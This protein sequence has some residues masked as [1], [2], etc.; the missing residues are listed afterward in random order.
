MQHVRGIGLALAVLASWGQAG[1]ATP[2]V[3]A[4]ELYNLGKFDDAIVAARRALEADADLDAARVV[5]ARASLERYRLRLETADRTAAEAA[6]RAVD[7]NRLAPS[8]Y[9]E[10]LVGLG[11]ALFVDDEGGLEDRFSAAAELFE[12]VL[13]RADGAVGA[14]SR[15]RVLEW[16]ANALDRQAQ[17]GPASGRHAT[18]ARLLERIDREVDANDRSV[19]ALY[20]Q[21]VASRGTGDLERAWGAAVAAW[22]RSR[23]LGADGASLRADLDRFVTTVLLPERAM[24][25]APDADPRPTLERLESGWR[26]FKEKWQA[27]GCP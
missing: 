1:P 8:D 6:L 24:E 11:V 22:L 26:A 16:W 20:W 4:R 9:V 10:W 5:L 21:V 15:E 18:Y 23:H 2:L 25:L 13:D 27:P 7:A 12:T 14:T 17:F 19:V 3:A